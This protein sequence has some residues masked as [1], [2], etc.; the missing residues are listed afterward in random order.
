[1]PKRTGVCRVCGREYQVCNT[2]YPSAFNWR[3]VACSPQCGE[4]YFR[5]VLKA[6][7]AEEPVEEEMPAE[8]LQEETFDPDA[9]IET[10]FGG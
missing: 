5:Q 3:E 1:M 6:R 9:E 10:F 7:E 2:V 8:T 4:E